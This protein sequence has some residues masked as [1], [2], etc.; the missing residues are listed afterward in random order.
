MMQDQIYRQMHLKDNSNGTRES[1]RPFSSSDETRTSEET[2]V[3]KTFSH[4]APINKRHE[5]Q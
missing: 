2:K 4:E 3:T 1:P 5:K